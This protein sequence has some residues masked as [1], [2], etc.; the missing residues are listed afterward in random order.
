MYGAR[1]ARLTSRSADASGGR[2]STV[3]SSSSR[4]ASRTRRTRCSTGPSSPSGA[5]ALEQRLDHL[6]VEQL[7]LLHP[8]D[9]VGYVG[10]VVVAVA[11]VPVVGVDEIERVLERGLV[12]VPALAVRMRIV[13]VIGVHAVA[14]SVAGA[15]LR[16]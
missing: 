10:Q 4:S 12:A 8:L 16:T 9:G 3:A 14:L 15:R 6:A 7:V 2:R 13:V 5:E 11:L 1:S